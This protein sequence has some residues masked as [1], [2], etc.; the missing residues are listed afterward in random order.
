M[1]PLTDAFSGEEMGLVFKIGSVWV[2]G[3]RLHLVIL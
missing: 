1:S 2:F 3:R